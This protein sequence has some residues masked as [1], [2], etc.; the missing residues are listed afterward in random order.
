MKLFRLT[1][2]LYAHDLRG[3]GAKKYGARWNNKGVPM[4]YTA[5]DPATCMIEF[6]V[7]IQNPK[8]F[9]NNQVL[10]EIEV[11]DTLAT[12]K[13]VNS[14]AL[15]DYWDQ[16]PGPMELK[17]IG[18]KF[19]ERRKQLILSVPCI[20][21]PKTRNYLLNPLHNDFGQVRITE[22]TNYPFEDRLMQ[23]IR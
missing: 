22:I 15:P 19:T 3:I 16:Y 2:P 8:L 21:V 11:P 9:P 13:R 6:M 20:P 23:L 7:H 5:P 14:R 1:N 4:L 17:L 12:I 18:D 10:V